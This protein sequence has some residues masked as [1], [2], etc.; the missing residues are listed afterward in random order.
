MPILKTTTLTIRVLG[1]LLNLRYEFLFLNP[2]AVFDLSCALLNHPVDDCVL[3]AVKNPDFDALPISVR[4]RVL[5]NCRN[6]LKADNQKALIK[7]LKD[8]LFALQKHALFQGGDTSPIKA[9]FRD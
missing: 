5:E 3:Q 9:V 1:K 8:A 7:N 2:E 6:T 4:A